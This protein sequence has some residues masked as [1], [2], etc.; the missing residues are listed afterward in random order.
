[1][2]LWTLGLGVWMF[3]PQPVSSLKMPAFHQ[4]KAGR[5]FQKPTLPGTTMLEK[6][7]AIS[8]SFVT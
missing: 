3:T 8:W 5:P 6:M 4:Q 1:M 2:F 7:P